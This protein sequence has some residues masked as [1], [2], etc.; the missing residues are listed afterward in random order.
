MTV[1]TGV[2]ARGRRQAA[3]AIA[4]LFLMWVVLVLA[5]LG[6]FFAFHE[7]IGR[8]L[9]SHQLPRKARFLLE[10]QSLHAPPK[11]AQLV[12]YEG[13]PSNLYADEKRIIHTG[14]NPLHN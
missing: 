3:G 8:L 12:D 9:T 13:H 4:V 2:K 14:P 7:D 11:P 10:T 1:S 5:Q 6:L